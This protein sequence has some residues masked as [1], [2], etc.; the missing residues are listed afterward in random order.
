M[1]NNLNEIKI[2]LKTNSESQ[3]LKFHN[4]IKKEI[5]M[6]IF[7][8][9]KTILKLSINKELFEEIEK[10]YKLR[11]FK[12]IEI[13]KYLDIIESIK[14]VIEKKET[15][16]ESLV[17]WDLEN[18]HYYNDFSLI[19]RYVK[20]ENQIKIMAYNEKYRKY[21]TINRLNFIL[22]KLKK[23]KWIIKETKDIADR[24]LIEE[25]NKYKNKIKELIVISNDSDFVQK[26]ILY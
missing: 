11:N 25:F 4:D 18:I 15:K 2:Y 9:N 8:I 14:K 23:R 19:S 16:I 7:F 5:L 22:N 12:I 24:I 20:K 26:L 6:L 3:E 13:N 21:E 1:S 17:L 10:I